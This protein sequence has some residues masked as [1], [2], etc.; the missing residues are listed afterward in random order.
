MS[1]TKNANITESDLRDL[2]IAVKDIVYMARR[3]ADGRRSGAPTI[4]NGAYSRLRE[5][6]DFDEPNDPDNRT[7]SL[8]PIHNFPW[9]TDGGEIERQ[10]KLSKEK[11]TNE[12]P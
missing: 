6:I 12:Q 4:F 10:S 7:D 5:I 11:S 8:R 2:K 3:Y 1:K 9:A